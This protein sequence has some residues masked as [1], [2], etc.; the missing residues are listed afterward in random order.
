MEIRKAELGD[1]DDLMQLAVLFYSEDTRFRGMLF[2]PYRAALS[3]TTVINRPEKHCLFVIEVNDELAGFFLGDLHQ[4]DFSSDQEAWERYLYI[5]P[6][7]RGKGYSKPLIGSFVNWA[8]ANDAKI[9]QGGL[10]SNIDP[11]VA[12]AAFEKQGFE[13]LGILVAYSGD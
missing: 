12:L 4:S 2:D 1:L 10:R 7:H 13:P 6:D 3:F 11:K 8:K 5:A 9:I